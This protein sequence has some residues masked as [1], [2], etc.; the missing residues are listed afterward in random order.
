MLQRFLLENYN[1]TE[2]E[3][4]LSDIGKIIDDF[5][6]WIKDRKG[7]MDT[8]EKIKAILTKSQAT[9]SFHH[10]LLQLIMVY[11][12]EFEYPSWIA[13]STQMG[14]RY[15]QWVNRDEMKKLASDPQQ[16]QWIDPKSLPKRDQKPPK[17]C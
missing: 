7:E 1:K 10:L 11:F 4:D 15:I 2:A 9:D 13:K 8:T 14:D 12:A 3:A 6:E 5:E 17:S 16:Y